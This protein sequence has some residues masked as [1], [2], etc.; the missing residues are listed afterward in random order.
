MD[1]IQLLGSCKGQPTSW[2]FPVDNRLPSL[3]NMRKA[4]AICKQCPII[5]E[6]LNY[7]LRNETHGVWGGLR[8]V[9]REIYRRKNNITLTP[10]ALVGQSSTV[11]RVARKIREAESNGKSL[12]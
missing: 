10:V 9:E 5:N 12:L 1:E 8:E 3:I 4:I 6:C 2:W 7:A 11:R